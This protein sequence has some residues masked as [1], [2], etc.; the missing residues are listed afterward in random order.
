VDVSGPAVNSHE[1][2]QCLYKM[3]GTD[4]ACHFLGQASS[5]VFI[6]DGKDLQL[7]T[8]IEK[9]NR[10]KAVIAKLV[11]GEIKLARIEKKL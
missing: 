2:I 8:V 4:G 7:L 11:D 9:I 1:L 6:D 5:G 10:E 3:V